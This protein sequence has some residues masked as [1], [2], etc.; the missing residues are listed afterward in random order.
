MDI[1]PN[2]TRRRLKFTLPGDSKVNSFEWPD[3]EV[4]LKSADELDATVG[5]F[6]P[7]GD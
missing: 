6:L 2:H 5:P 4:A 1:I 3:P 7:A